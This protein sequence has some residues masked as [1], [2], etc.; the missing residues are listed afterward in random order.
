MQTHTVWMPSKFGKAVYQSSDEVSGGG[1]IQPGQQS[2]SKVKKVKEDSQ[3]IA[4]VVDDSQTERIHLE[5][6]LKD[7]GFEVLLANSGNKAKK[8]AVL[9]LPSIIFLDII[10]ED[11]DGY[12]T[13]RYLRRHPATQHIPIIMVSSKANPVDIQWAEKL[14]ANAYIVKPFSADTVLQKLATLRQ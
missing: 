11:G 2:A 6:I 5:H 3:G 7:A 12:Q 1:A 13:C 8:L 9:H 4:L 14:G 10:M